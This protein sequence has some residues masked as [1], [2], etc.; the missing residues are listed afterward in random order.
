MGRIYRVAFENVAVAAAQD[1]ISVYGAAGK[2]L[3]ILHRW[4]GATNT[5]IPN[6]QMLAIRERFLPATVTAGSGGGGG[7]VVKVDQGD[8]AASFTA[9]INDTVKATTSGTAQ[10]LFETGVHIFNGYDD[11]TDSP[12]PVGPSEAYVFELLSTVNGPVNLSGG[13]TVE[14]IGG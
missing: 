8:A 12:Y 2:M 4:V 3:R 5:T 11:E 7:T 14:E 6:A 1:M 9:R 10:V 13:V